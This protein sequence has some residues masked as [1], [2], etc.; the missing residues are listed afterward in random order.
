MEVRTTVIKDIQITINAISIFSSLHFVQ[1]ESGK[2]KFSF[3]LFPGFVSLRQ[4]L[5]YVQ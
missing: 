4:P 3:M 2:K 1:C 5:E